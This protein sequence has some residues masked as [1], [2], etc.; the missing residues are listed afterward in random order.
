MIRQYRLKTYMWILI[1]L[2]MVVTVSLSGCGTVAGFG[3]DIKDT[4][5]W[6]KDQIKKI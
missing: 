4:A 3:A 1:L 2:M 6:T 5:D